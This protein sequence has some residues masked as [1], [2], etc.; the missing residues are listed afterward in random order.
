MDR[1][2]LTRVDIL[3]SNNVWWDDQFQ[4]GDPSD[5]TW[6]LTGL[7]F[8][9]QVKNSDDDTTPLLSLSSLSGQIVVAD[10]N[11]RIVGMLVTDTVI[12]SALPEGEYVYDLIMVNHATGQTDGV[13]YGT[14]KVAQGITI[15]PS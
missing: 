4:L 14:L 5:F 10:A 1:Q 7:D 13:M 11:A 3:I 9:L 6:T 15:G 12:R 2:A 8:Y